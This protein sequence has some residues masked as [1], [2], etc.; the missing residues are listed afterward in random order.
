MVDTTIYGSC[1]WYILANE[2]RHEE[3]LDRRVRPIQD[4]IWSKYATAR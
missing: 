2:L 1:S 3:G 4:Q